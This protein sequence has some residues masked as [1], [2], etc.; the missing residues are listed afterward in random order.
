MTREEKIKN[1]IDATESAIKEE[2][3]KGTMTTEKRASILEN[4]NMIICLIKD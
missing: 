3:E 2:E 4:M 1:I